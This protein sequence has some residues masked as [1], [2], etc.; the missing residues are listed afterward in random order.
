[1]SAPQ[2][3]DFTGLFRGGQGTAANAPI[4]AG[5]HQRICEMIVRRCLRAGGLSRESQQA[6]TAHQGTHGQN[7][8]LGPKNLPQSV[9]L[10]H[11]INTIRPSQPVSR[12]TT[13]DTL[14]PIKD[15]PTARDKIA[16]RMRP[17]PNPYSWLKRCWP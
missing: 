11:K 16:A 3:C 7:T 14:T 8:A 2:V 6:D 15:P 4:G 17:H 1:M 13:E 9:Y 10:Q 5:Q 12:P